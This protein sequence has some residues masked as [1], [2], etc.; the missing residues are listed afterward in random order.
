MSVLESCQLR[1]AYCLP[2][3]SK[4]VLK[5]KAWLGLAHYEKIARVLARLSLAKIRFTGG[6]PLLRPELAKIIRTFADALPDVPLALTTNALRLDGALAKAL[7]QSGLKALT[8]HLDTLDPQHYKKIMGRG[9]LS[10]VLDAIKRALDLGFVTKLNMVVQKNLNHNELPDFLELSKNTGVEVRFIEMM[11]TGSASEFVKKNFM[12]GQEILEYLGQRF[13]I[14]PTYRDNPS[15]PAE[16]FIA[17]ELNIRFGLIA[18]DTRPF[19]ENCTRLR[20]SATG[21]LHTC[22]YDDQ[23]AYLGLDDDEETIWHRLQE[24]IAGKISLHPMIASKRRIF[25]MSQIGG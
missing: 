1:C 24:K 18:S 7:K 16:G 25:S 3:G 2:E 14:R 19:C 12:S 10:Q 5:A 17:E 13:C 23:G 4:S 20:L 8:I 22:L 9:E 15:D 11:N 21:H 6:E